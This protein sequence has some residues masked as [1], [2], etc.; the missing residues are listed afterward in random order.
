MNPSP[1]R[2][3]LIL[4][5]TAVFFLLPGCTRK[6]GTG[7]IVVTGLTGSAEKSTQS[8]WEKTSPGD[9]IG[10]NQLIRTL[11]NSTIDL[12]L[13][14]Q[15]GIRL[16]AGSEFNPA[17]IAPSQMNF[18]MNNGNILVRVGKLSQGT[19]VS[20]ETPTAV[21]SVRGTQFWGQVNRADRTGVFAVREGNLHIKSISSGAETDI[22]AGRAVDLTPGAEKLE[23][24]PAKEGELQ[25]MN[26]IDDIK[27]LPESP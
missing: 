3:C 10:E 21:A 8:G 20:V 12:S 22:E 24:R 9:R 1:I 16:L 13:F 23:T 18:K 19:G 15:V 4:C 6:A 5:L 17:S 7:S 25:A 26:Q 11:D 2:N 14:G 27:I